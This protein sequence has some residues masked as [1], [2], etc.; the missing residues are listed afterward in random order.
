MSQRFGSTGPEQGWWAIF[1]LA[2]AVEVIL[3]TSPFWLVGL[4]FMLIIEVIAAT[5]G[6]TKPRAVDQSSRLRFRG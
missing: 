5:R 1:L 4:I 2:C 3:I 6:T